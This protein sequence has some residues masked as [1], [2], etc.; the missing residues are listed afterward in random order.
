MCWAPN[1]KL[2]FSYILINIHHSFIIVIIAQNEYY[3]KCM[4]IKVSSLLPCKWFNIKAMPWTM[5]MYCP[6]HKTLP[7]S[8][9]FLNWISVRFYGTG[10]NCKYVHNHLTLLLGNLFF[11]GST[12]LSG[13]VV[14]ILLFNSENY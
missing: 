8:S 14:A 4:K 2:S 13:N 9:A 12:L 3:G 1:L 7:I 11:N 5:F 10:S 6:F